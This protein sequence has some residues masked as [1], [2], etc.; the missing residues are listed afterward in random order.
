MGERVEYHPGGVVTGG[1]D[2]D[3][4]VPVFVMCGEEFTTPRRM[5]E[6]MDEAGTPRVDDGDD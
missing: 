5:K 1:K 6:L 2:D 4:S 3:D